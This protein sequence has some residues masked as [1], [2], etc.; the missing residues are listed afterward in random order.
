MT[1]PDSGYEYGERQFEDMTKRELRPGQGRISGFISATLGVLSL[2]TVLCWLFPEQLTTPELREIYDIELLRILLKVSMWAAILFGLFSF[3]RY[4]QRRLG[5]TGIVSTVIAFALGGWTMEGRSVHPTEVFAGVD[6]LVLDFLGSG[7]L[8]LAIEKLFPK[9]PD[10][11]VLRPDFKLDLSYFVLNHLIVGFLLLVGNGFAPAAFA[12]AVN[13]NVQEFM[14]SLP[15]AAQLVVLMLA[16]D[17]VQYWVHRI[18][19]EV[20]WLWPFHAVHHCAEHMDWLAGSRTHIVQTL[21]DRSLVMVPLFLLGPH[22]RALNLYVVVA[23]FQFVFIHANT[24][25]PFGPLKYVFV[26]PQFHHW[27]HSKD[28][29]A[30]DTNYA[31]HFPLWDVLFRSFHLPGDHWPKEY[32]TVSPLPDT[33]AG[34]FAYPFT[35]KLRKS[36]EPD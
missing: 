27:H 8:F 20:G 19:H 1:E 18:F 36:A 14:L 26:T 2:L 10:Q 16:A 35:K 29:P 28:D 33:M 34:Q 11:A 17:F 12:W 21:C 9:Y 4:G 13:A 7:I 23:A 32:G 5:L 31:V 15:L 6:W 22:P 30:I 3:V 24:R 25:V